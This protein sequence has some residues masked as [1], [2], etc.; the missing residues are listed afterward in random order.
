FV[1]EGKFYSIFS[2]LFGIGFG[3]Q[4]QRAMDRNQPFIGRFSRRLLILLFFGIFHAIVLFVGDILTVYALLGFVL[5][6]F[7]NSSNKT[8]LRL[9]FI[10]LVIPVVQYGWMWYQQQGAPPVDQ[11]DSNAMFAQIVTTYQTGTF[12]EILFTNFGGLVF[13]RYPDLIFTGRFF[14]VFAMFLVGFFIAKNRWFAEVPERRDQLKRIMLWS[15]LVGIPC[16]LVMA[17]MMSTGAYYSMAPSGIVEPIVYA[18][19][20]PA[21]GISYACAIALAYQKDKFKALLQA[22][23]PLGR[24]ALTNY[25]MQSLI[26]CLIFQ[27]Y[28]LGLFGHIGPVFFTLIGLSILILQIIF[29]NWWLSKYQYGPAEWLWRSMTYRKIQP[30]KVKGNTSL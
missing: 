20:V 13:G 15:A 2:L 14:K 6:L 25:L 16:N 22:L 18:F 27:S 17:H 29:S 9:A 5:I 3:L 28:G 23:A 8:L 11:S 12:G 30:I 26:G 21:L 24:M 7:R 10:L 4:I 1:T 19:G